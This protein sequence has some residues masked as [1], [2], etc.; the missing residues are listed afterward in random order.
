MF[1]WTSTNGV[2][3]TSENHGNSVNETLTN[4]C[5]CTNLERLDLSRLWRT[6]FP[7]GH[8]C[9]I[10]SMIY[11]PPP[12]SPNLNNEQERMVRQVIQRN[13]HLRVLIIGGY[14]KHRTELLATISDATLPHLQD[15]Q[16]FFGDADLERVIPSLQSA[17]QFLEN[18]PRNVRKLMVDLEIVIE[19]DD[20]LAFAGVMAAFPC[21][22]CL[23]HK[24]LE[25]LFLSMLIASEPIFEYFLLPFLQS[26]SQQSL[27]TAFVPYIG[28]EE[29][30]RSVISDLGIP[31]RG[32][33]FHL[34]D[35]SHP[36]DPAAAAVLAAEQNW[37]SISLHGS[38]NIT[39]DT[40]IGESQMTAVLLERCENLERLEIYSCEIEISSSQIQQILCSSPCLAH[41]GATLRQA[42]EIMGRNPKLSAHDAIQKPWTCS[43]MK[44]LQLEI[45][46]VPRPD[47]MI[48]H[49][50]FPV[51]GDLFRG[52]VE[53]SHQV[54]RRIYEQLARLTNLSGLQLGGELWEP[55]D[56]TH[57]WTY[58]AENRRRD[59]DM[60]FQLN[61][62]EMSLASGLDLLSG[63]KNMRVLDV[64]R[65]AH[66]IGVPDRL[67]DW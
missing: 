38:G 14:I 8:D 7:V 43:R 9:D 62:L 64:S 67:T 29:R 24:S 59:V 39:N 46:G 21:T 25:L 34:E 41:L 32:K 22:P 65:M 40:G 57:H 2:P 30:I 31:L 44:Q 58:D 23:P 36:T 12:Y 18:C 27:K 11:G 61:C 63:L 50:G 66:R 42:D 56:V 20:D 4:A 28:P 49:A 60:A 19:H 35:H 26:C 37:A 48:D 15:L 47:I 51:Q 53:E 13:P 5:I 17:K 52:T 33:G 54:Q 10:E 45:G 1:R 16:L 3:S 55:D 6:P